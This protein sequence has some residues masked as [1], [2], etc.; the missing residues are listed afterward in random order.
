MTK[1]SPSYCFSC[2]RYTSVWNQNEQIRLAAYQWL[3]NKHFV[4]MYLKMTQRWVIF[5]IIV[6]TSVVKQLCYVTTFLSLKQLSMTTG[7]FWTYCGQSL[8]GLYLFTEVRYR[9]YKKKVVKTLLNI[10]LAVKTEWPKVWAF[11]QQF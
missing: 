1:I 9:I 3:L 4:E 11:L 2:P 8:A 5:K 7:N 10:S 6:F